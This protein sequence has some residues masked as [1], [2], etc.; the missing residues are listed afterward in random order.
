MTPSV[1][2]PVIPLVMGSIAFTLFV[3]VFVAAWIVTMR[4]R[5]LI[6]RHSV[7]SGTDNTTG[8][9]QSRRPVR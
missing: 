8:G 1:I 2:P 9:E 3:V 4:G 5:R 7:K 6:R